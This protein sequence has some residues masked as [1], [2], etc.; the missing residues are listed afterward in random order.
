MVDLKVNRIFTK[1][2]AMHDFLVHQS[3]IQFKVQV[4]FGKSG[5]LKKKKG[6]WEILDFDFEPSSSN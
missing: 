1:N 5:N 2:T 3:A 6:R 4:N